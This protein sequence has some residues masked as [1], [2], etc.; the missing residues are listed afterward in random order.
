MNAS[1]I[2]VNGVEV[3]VDDSGWVLLDGRRLDQA[4][5]IQVAEA[6]AQAVQDSIYR[7]QRDTPRYRS[8]A[9][10]LERQ[11]SPLGEAIYALRRVF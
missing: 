9:G 11:Q 3:R 8:S 2:V 6:L 7:G 4:Q 5:A 1:T 10:I